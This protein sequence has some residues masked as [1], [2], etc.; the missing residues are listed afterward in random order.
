M[1]RK[2]TGIIMHC[3]TNDISDRVIKKLILQKKKQNSTRIVMQTWGI[4]PW[5]ISKTILLDDKKFQQI[6]K[7]KGI[8]F[9]VNKNLNMSPLNGGKL[10]L[11]NKGKSST[12]FSVSL[13]PSN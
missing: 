13:Q 6:Y 5:N 9:I 10:Q 2:P 8:S 12:K 4:I 7:S 3:G 1:Q 11:R